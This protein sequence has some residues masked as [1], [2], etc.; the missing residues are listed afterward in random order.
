MLILLTCMLWILRTLETPSLMAS[1]FSRYRGH[2]QNVRLEVA[3]TEIGRRPNPWLRDV[4]L[5][6]HI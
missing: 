4:R 2:S 1:T 3:N 5:T 6:F